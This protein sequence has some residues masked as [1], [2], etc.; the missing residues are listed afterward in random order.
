M[1]IF[2]KKPFC[3]VLRKVIATIYSLSI[4][5]LSESGWVGTLDVT[6]TYLSSLNQ[7]WNFINFYLQLLK[8]LP[9][10]TLAVFI[11]QQVPDTDSTEEFS[12]LNWTNQTGWRKVGVNFKTDAHTLIFVVYRYRN[13]L[14]VKDIEFYLKIT[15]KIPGSRAKTN[16]IIQ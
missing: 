9:K 8:L 4:F 14:G 10:L 12:C 3:N 16:K 11:V 15:H 5:F 13:N 2:T 1:L 6:E 7:I